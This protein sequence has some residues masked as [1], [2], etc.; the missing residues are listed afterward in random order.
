MCKGFKVFFFYFCLSG[1]ISRGSE[2][3]VQI[4]SLCVRVLRNYGGMCGYV[5]GFQGKCFRLLLVLSLCAKVLRDLLHPVAMC[6][7]FK[8]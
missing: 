2:E 1:V 8:G 3:D 5:Q 6:K 4:L 7:G